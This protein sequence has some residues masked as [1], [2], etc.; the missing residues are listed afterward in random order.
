MFIVVDFPAPLDPKRPRIPFFAILKDMFLIANHY[1][2][3]WDKL[4]MLCNK[5]LHVKSFVLCYFCFLLNKVTPPKIP[6]LKGIIRINNL[7][8]QPICF[9]ETKMVLSIG[10]GRETSIGNC[11]LLNH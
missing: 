1:C 2:Y 5:I 10:E 11:P 8:I 4:S 6:M 7:L 9:W 3:L